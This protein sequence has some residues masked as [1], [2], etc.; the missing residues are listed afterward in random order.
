MRRR[1]LAVQSME[2]SPVRLAV[3]P[4]ESSRDTQRVDVIA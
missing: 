3:V 1:R 2:R 4:A